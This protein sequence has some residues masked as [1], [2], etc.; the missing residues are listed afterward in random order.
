M[1]LATAEK[2]PSSAPVLRLE[3]RAKRRPSRP[4]PR[5]R[6]DPI[7][8]GP[9]GVVDRVRL[10][11]RPRS[12]LASLFGVMIGGF[13]PVATYVVAHTELDFDRS[14]YEQAA[15]Y[16]VAGGLTFS[17]FTMYGWGALAFKHRAKAFGFVV[18]LE[19]VMVTC[20]TRWLALV[21]LGYLAAINGVET[22]CN[23]ARPE[24][25]FK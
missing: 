25:G 2:A 21:A 14:L 1:T 17:A 4:E 6:P 13:V 7:P 20:H 19:G 8:P 22:A 15:A 9:L 3:R 18:L 24:E 5:T 10:A 23:L 11:L 16:F 12:R